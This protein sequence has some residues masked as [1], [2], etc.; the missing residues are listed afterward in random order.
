MAR[1]EP[2]IWSWR[3]GRAGGLRNRSQNTNR[4]RRRLKAAV[5]PTAVD[6]EARTG[7]TDDRTPSIVM[8]MTPP[9][10]RSGPDRARHQRNARCHDVLDQR[11]ISALRVVL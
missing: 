10:C 4:R 3:S 9:Q 7:I 11:Q 8:S 5:A 1:R 2:S 6:K